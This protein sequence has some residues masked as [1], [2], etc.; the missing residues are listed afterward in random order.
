MD[1][2]EVERILG[3]KNI[4]GKRHY[5]VKWVGY[6]KSQS[7]W[8]P[9]EYLAEAQKMIKDFYARLEKQKK[10]QSAK[11]PSSKLGSQADL[12]PSQ[13]DEQPDPE[14][15][16]EIPSI[17]ETAKMTQESNQKAIRDSQQEQLPQK[18]MGGGKNQLFI[19]GQIMI[20]GQLKFLCKDSEGNEILKNKQHFFDNDPLTLLKYY[21]QFVKLE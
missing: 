10:K 19:S 18:A 20:A 14:S 16:K 13:Q 5:L 4:K 6:D 1:Q 2:F 3:C 7:T 8:E 15:L 12:K 11:K 9:Q 21:D 17:V